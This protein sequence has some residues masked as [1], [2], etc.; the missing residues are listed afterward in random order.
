[1]NASRLRDFE[2]LRTMRSGFQEGCRHY[3]ILTYAWLLSR[4]GANKE[5]VRVAVT[6][7][8]RECNPPA[9][10][11]EINTAIK[12]AYSRL[13]RRLRDQTIADWLTIMPAEANLLER[14]PSATRF[15]AQAQPAELNMNKRER[16]AAIPRVIAGLKRVPPVREMTAIFIKQGYQISLGTIHGDYRDLQIDSGRTVAARN[17]RQQAQ[18]ALPSLLSNA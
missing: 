16:Q 4:G 11:G 15:A 3:A 12:S 2:L 1:L 10:Q 6:K 9:D 7:L 14:L 17:A 13:F 18:S 5:A 8:A